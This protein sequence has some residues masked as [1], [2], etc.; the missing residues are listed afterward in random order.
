MQTEQTKVK[1]R[2]YIGESDTWKGDNLYAAIVK[3]AKEMKSREFSI[4]T[5]GST[6]DDE[7]EIERL[8]KH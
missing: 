1:L 8:R 2:I 7:E 4:V 5:S 3:R 6:L